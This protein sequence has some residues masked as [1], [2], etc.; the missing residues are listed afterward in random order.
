MKAI[1]SEE[2]HKRMLQTPLLP[3]LAS[4]ALPTV[5]SQLVTILYN[6]ADTWFVSQISTSAS[7]AV[8]ICF[9]LQS[10][11]Q[12]C[13]FG[14]GM[15]CGSLISR[16]LGA[17]QDKQAATYAA[18]ALIMAM[19]IGAV[20]GISGSLFTTPLMRI[21]GSTDTILPYAC[22]Y[23]RYILIA[24][25]IMCGSFVLNNI[26]R[27]EGE[28]SFAMVGLCTGSFL[29][30]VLDPLLIFV[31]DMGT[32]G[33]AI[34]TAVSQLV[35]FAIL[36][37]A[38]L[39]KKSI[40]PLK[41]SKISHDPAD[42]A[43][44][45][46]TGFPTICRQGMGSL[47]TA[48]LNGRAALYGDAAVAAVTIVNKV[49]NLVRNVILGIGQGFQPIAGYNFGAQNKKR[50]REVFWLSCEI[51]TVFCTLAGI[52]IAF[53]AEPIMLWF[54]ND[55]EVAAIGKAALYY[56][57]MVM[58]LM[59][60]STYVNQLYQCLGFRVPA[61]VLACCRQGICFLPLAFLLP[62]LIGLSGVEM[63]QPG[64][65]LLTFLIS[66]PFLIL[67]MKKVL[68]DPTVSETENS[69]FRP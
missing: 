40:V 50:T 4:L 42:Y 53:Y 30:I 26:L 17:K 22:A 20:I 13:G 18:S 15:G 54:R 68:A 66:V 32:A 44:I 3:L 11:I 60:F 45:L 36:L 2:Q 63:L 25:P 28:S 33:A 24:A 29:N 61:T 27:S 38:F 19:G 39:R 48:V 52:I 49:Y 56:S 7:A 6:T 69:N 46:S 55:P 10:I 47:S 35:S 8:G 34:A 59:A 64:A 37:S 14:C 9:A 23:A 5:A 65:D 62:S 58:P 1:S 21:L 31:C 16:A 51:G 43:K 12:A 57:C 67:F 41:I